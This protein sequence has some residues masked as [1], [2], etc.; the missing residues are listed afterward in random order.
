MAL[1][2]AS[3]WWITS[4]GPGT[5]TCSCASVTTTAISMMR[6][7]LGLRPV[8]SQSSQ[9]RFRSDLGKSGVLAGAGVSLETGE[10]MRKLSPTLAPHVFIQSFFSQLFPHRGLCAGLGL[11]TAGAGVV[12]HPPGAPRSP[13]PG[14]GARSICPAYPLGCP[15]ESGRLHLG[16]SAYWAYPACLG[17]SSFTGVDAAGWLE[18]P[19]PGA[20]GLDGT[21]AGA[22]GGAGGCVCCALGGGGAAVGAVPHLCAGAALWLQPKHAGAVAGR[23]AQKHAAGRLDWPAAGGCRAVADAGGWQPVVAVGLGAVDGLSAAADVGFSHF[24]C[25]A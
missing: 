20:A 7:V 25:A 12:A 6:S 4:T 22:A 19:A 10:S 16:K 17:C 5:R 24:Y 21:R 9:T 18:C 2:S 13:A 15:P 1:S 8:I 23:S 3:L 11:A 14:C